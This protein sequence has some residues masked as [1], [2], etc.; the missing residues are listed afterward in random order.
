MHLLMAVISEL[1]FLHFLVYV[2]SSF[3]LNCP[4]VTLLRSFSILSE[5][6]ETIVLFPQGPAA[7]S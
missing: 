5:Q 6:E 3:L 2:V 1:G 4:A 7:L